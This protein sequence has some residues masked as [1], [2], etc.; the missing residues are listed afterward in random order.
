[1]KNKHFCVAWV[2]ALI[3]SAGCTKAPS[4]ESSAVAQIESRSAD[5]LKPAIEMAIACAAECTTAYDAKTSKDPLSS[6]ALPNNFSDILTDIVL[7]KEFSN[8]VK[9]LPTDLQASFK[10][11]PSSNVSGSLHNIIEWKGGQAYLY[12]F[13][14]VKQNAS[15]A[16]YADVAIDAN[17][18]K[19][20]ILVRPTEHL[21]RYFLSGPDQLQAILLLQAADGDLIS[22]K[23]TLILAQN[24][25]AKIDWDANRFILPLKDVRAADVS[26]RLK[27]LNTKFSNGHL[28]GVALPD[29]FDKAKRIMQEAA[30]Y[31]ADLNFAHCIANISPAERI[32]IIQESGTRAITQD[33]TDKTGRLVEVDVYVQDGSNTRIYRYFKSQTDCESSLAHR[34]A[35]PA[36]YR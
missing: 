25:A 27:Y 7:Q 34:Q 30:W 26:A 16:K 6:H 13:V 9:S 5:P 3:L 2:L 4:P 1:M 18:K 33:K 21:D 14:S 20:A 11:T 36:R 24:S 31:S 12:G 22:A 17:T 8:A 15:L 23:Q 19:L 28:E 10:M 32:S 35:I 29:E